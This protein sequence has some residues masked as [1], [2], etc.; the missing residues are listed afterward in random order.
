MA[1]AF[2]AISRRERN[3][4]TTTTDAATAKL[5]A[6]SALAHAE[7]QIVVNVLVTTNPY[8]FGLLVST[9]YINGFISGISSPTNVNYAY[10]NG[11]PLSGADNLLNLANLLYS[12]RPPVFVPT[13]SI[14]SNDFRFYLDLNRNGKFEDTSSNTPNVEVDEF[15]GNVTTNGTIPEV[16]DPQWIGVLAR[17]DL[18][19]GPNNYFV[20]RYAFFAAPAGNTLDLNYIHNQALNQGLSASDGFFRNQGVG[21]W[22]INL[23]AFLTD[24]NTNQWDTTIAPYNYLEPA[25][26]NNGFAFQDAF[27][28]L[29]DRY[30]GISLPFA[31]ALFPNNALALANGP[32]TYF[33]LD[34]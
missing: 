7:A 23:A 26:V 9:N 12:P 29:Y 34:F 3:S 21:S 8:N 4:V 10:T 16:G 27:S 11:N 17:P 5:A 20:A 19:H 24:L 30:N 6:D 33:R 1:V 2:L 15:T 28:L 18:P 31:S 25:S 13:N 22:E 32:L 14:G